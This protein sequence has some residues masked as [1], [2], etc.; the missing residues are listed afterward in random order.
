MKRLILIVV[1]A[2]ML[3]AWAGA[4]FAGGR[5]YVY[6]SGA[7]RYS[8]PTRTYYYGTYYYPRRYYRSPRYYRHHYRRAYYYSPC[9]YYDYWRP[10]VR[11]YYYRSY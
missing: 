1:A 3:G 9:V 6:T 8:R 10:P 7:R 4:A 5:V 11:V 2:L